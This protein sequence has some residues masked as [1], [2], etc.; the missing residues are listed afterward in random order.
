MIA[1]APELSS[2]DGDLVLRALDEASGGVPLVGSI[3]LD[4]TTKN[5]N[6]QT[7]LNGMYWGDRLALLLIQGPLRP[8]FFRQELRKVAV[9]R[10]EALVT[11][12]E[13]NAILRINHMP[14]VV[15]LEKVGFVRNGEYDTLFA[16]P[17]FLQPPDGADFASACRAI[18]PEGALYCL[19]P[20]PQGSRL[21]F[22]TVA[23]SFVLDSANEMAAAVRRAAAA[24]DFSLLLLLSCFTRNVA[25]GDPLEEMALLRRELAGIGLPFVFAYAGGE[26]CPRVLQEGQDADG[27]R[28]GGERPQAE[29]KFR[30]EFLQ[31]SLV[32][33]LL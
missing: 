9:S 16:I 14:A 24:G 8:A 25:L 28:A 10:E 18:G 2:L 32:G 15:Y 20:V 19:S 31:Y 5:R 30:N 3:A 21:R 13:G 1:F 22:G 11:A 29:E 17:F 7:V 26:F 27:R 6:A 12:T 4:V 33:C 23:E